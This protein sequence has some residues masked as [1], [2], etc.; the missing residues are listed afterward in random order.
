MTRDQLLAALDNA[1]TILNNVYDPA[2]C[3]GLIG[4]DARMQLRSAMY[5]LTSVSQEVKRDGQLRDLI[6]SAK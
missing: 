1:Y 2:Y 6:E 5:H 4:P 3:A